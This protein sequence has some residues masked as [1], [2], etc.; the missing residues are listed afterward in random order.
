ME[1]LQEKRVDSKLIFKGKILTLKY[2]T[3]VLPNGA[4]STREIIEHPGAVAV[5]PIANDGRIVLVRQYRYPIG[6]VM[7]EI[8]AGKLDQGEQPDA[9][10]RR[11]LAEETGYIAEELTKMT[12]IYTTPG[13][14]DEIIH[15]YVAKNLTMTEQHPDEDE[16]INVELF[17]KSQLKEMIA[18]GTICDAKSLI[19][20][21]MAGI[22]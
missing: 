22:V 16:F 10:A 1:N 20:L 7:L 6:Q 18:N 4:E 3:V 14:T 15:I 11:E 5:V 2:D 8:P 17:T 12:S 19:G 13:F 21:F 9:C